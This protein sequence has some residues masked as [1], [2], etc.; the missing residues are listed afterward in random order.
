MW[1]VFV[2]DGKGTV[3]QFN[4]RADAVLLGNQIR[5][6]DGKRVEVYE[7]NYTG[8]HYVGEIVNHGGHECRVTDVWDDDGRNGITIE[9][10]GGYGFPVD[11]YD[12]QL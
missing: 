4:N 11:I 2:F 6:R 8:K 7:T 3:Y 1:K 5:N 9:P 12:E 10:T